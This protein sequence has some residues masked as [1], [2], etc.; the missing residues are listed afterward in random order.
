M[1]VLYNHSDNIITDRV[2]SV[3]PGYDTIKTTNRLLDGS[4]HTQVIGTGARF[5]NVRLLC[6]LTAKNTID[7]AEATGA[8]VKVVGD[9]MYYKGI[10]RDAPSW[11]KQ[12]PV[13]ETEIVLMVEEEGA[14]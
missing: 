5:V 2:T 4:W 13:Y 10:I 1:A 14:V 6:N 12:Y 3:I 7:T 9:D 8:P 11:N